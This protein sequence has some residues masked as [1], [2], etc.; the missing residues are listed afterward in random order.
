M[1]LTLLRRALS[2]SVHHAPGAAP[3]CA[4][5]LLAGA[6]LGATVPAAASAHAS[7]SPGYEDEQD[8]AAAGAT[9]VSIAAGRQQALRSAPAA[10][11]V[12]TAADIAAMGATDLSQALETVPGL[13]VLYAN[14][15]YTPI[16]AF[17]G[18]AT[19]LNPQV[20]MMIN[21]L[22]MNN[23]V[24]SNRGSDTGDMPLENVER[25]EV[26]RGPGS[27]LYGANAFAGVI[28]IITKSAEQLRGGQAGGR[29][30][31]WRGRDG[32]LQ[33]GGALGPAQAAFYLGRNVTAGQD[34]RIERDL[35]SQLDAVLHTQASQ[36]PG[37]V[38]QAQSGV[39][40]GGELAWQ[41]WRLRANY[42]FRKVGFGT[43]IADS[44][45]APVRGRHTRLNSE[46]NYQKADWA[47]GWDLGARLEFSEAMQLQ[48]ETLPHVFPAGAFGG[49]FP[50][51]V[52]GAPTYHIR[53]VGLSGTAL[54]SGLAHHRL[55][56]GAGYEDEDLYQVTEVKNF[57]FNPVPGAF[58][59]L[60]PLPG[61]ID[62]ANDAA[63]AW[64]LPDRRRVNYQFLQ[65]EWNFARDWTLTAGLRR[66][67]YSDFGATTNPRLAL[68]WDAAYNL[69]LKALHGRAFRAPSFVEE[70][71]GVN[72][73]VR[74]NPQIQPERIATSELILAW[75]PHTEL[76]TS[77]TL[78]HYHESS[79]IQQVANARGGGSTVQN[80]GSQTGRGLELEARW[81]PAPGL[82][83]S[84]S[85]S[86]QHSRAQQSGHDAGLAPHRHLA[87]RADWR[88]APDW[89]LGLSANA[90]GARGRLPRDP[91]AELGGYTALDAS[92]RREQL[93]RDWE[94]RLLVRNLLDRAF[95][96]PDAT[97][98]N[99][100]NDLPMPRRSAAV[101]LQRHF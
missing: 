15:G 81:Q 101:Q 43:G 11:T 69:V 91:R 45:E 79:I 22:S 89:Q 52:L 33:Y 32:W 51:G 49:L 24:T 80:A 3:W 40:M 59:P 37:Q 48:P 19:N 9:M 86:L 55:L 78:F 100:P 1:R 10:V 74:G 42:Q 28:N 35:Q 27:A 31:S 96:E 76:E 98:G 38:M 29:I 92:L 53:R 68:V 20:L 61:L 85:Y 44:L 82:R 14:Q 93:W 71:P 39:T 95:R 73:V 18:I 36:A 25:I 13:H 50:Q 58:P 77:L 21:G 94:L 99:I 4:A 26:I 83:L 64:L 63:L 2:A 90:L 66:D 60:L 23:S 5:L 87:A 54:Y 56:L 6:G 70:Y 67:G 17:R 46:L 41:D 57:R 12:I 47:P 62:A 16:Y 75:Q 34:G 72:P 88:L 84:A 65:D 8:L 30:G 7:A 97:T